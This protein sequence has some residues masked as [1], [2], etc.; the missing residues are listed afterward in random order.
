MG[1][2]HVKS[3]PRER[4]REKAPV[5]APYHQLE[6]V[7]HHQIGALQLQHPSVR[8]GVSQL[9]QWRYLRL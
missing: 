7:V 9:K 1:G 3:K 6:G 8:L 5:R 2:I 4:L